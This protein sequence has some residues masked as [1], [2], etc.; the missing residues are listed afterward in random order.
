MVE[1]LLS[2]GANVNAEDDG[3]SLPLHYLA[4]STGEEVPGA[5]LIETAKVLLANGA[6]VNQKGEF[7]STPLEDATKS[8]KKDLA[9]LLRQNVNVSTDS[10]RDAGHDKK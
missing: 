2:M 6:R 3:G 7:G 4:D 5:G 1:L 10:R 9:T 8:G